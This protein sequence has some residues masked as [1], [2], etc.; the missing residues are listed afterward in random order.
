MSKISKEQ[1]F[2]IS[3]RFYHDK[4]PKVFVETG[5]FR[6]ATIERI[7]ALF[8]VIHTFELNR[9]L[10][11]MAAEKFQPQQNIYCHL[12]NSVEGLEQLSPNI[13]EP[14]VFWLDAHYSG[15]GTTFGSEETPLLKE[16]GLICQRKYK[17]IIIIDDMNCFGVKAEFPGDGMYKPFVYDWRSTTVKNIKRSIGWKITHL[18]NPF[19]KYKL[20]ILTNLNITEKLQLILMERLRQIRYKLKI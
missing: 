12:E 1:L 7:N 13:K 20:I 8:S 6:G 17:D 11:E 18:L 2:S 14:I 15:Q 10:W 16:L 3:H 9:E 4:L 5:T 19:D